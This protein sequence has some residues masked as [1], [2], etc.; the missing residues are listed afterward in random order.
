[1]YIAAQNGHTDA[2]HTLL[3]A[4]ANARTAELNGQPTLHVAAEKAQKT[5]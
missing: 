4:G 5:W 2:L 3:K 1:M